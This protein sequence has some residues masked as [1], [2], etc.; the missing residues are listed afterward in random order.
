MARFGFD[1]RTNR[2]IDEGVAALSVNP[3][4]IEA[5]VQ[6]LLRAAGTN[7]SS[8]QNRNA[9]IANRGGLS[10]SFLAAAN[11]GSAIQSNASVAPQIAQLG[12][13][14]EN[15]RAEALRFLVGLTENRNQL[16]QQRSDANNNALLGS[17]TGLLGRASD[18]ALSRL[19]PKPN[20]GK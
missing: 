6:Q 7:L 15:S 10:S 11:R 1:D 18:F 14:A 9:E 12:L 3:Q 8:T 17:I 19:L 20:G 5:I 13:S 4:S 16:Q 2:G